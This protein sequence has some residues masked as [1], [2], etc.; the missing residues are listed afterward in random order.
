MV[1]W[2]L[3]ELISLRQDEFDAHVR[4]KTLRLAFV[5]MSN[6]GKS[7]RSRV[8]RNEEDFLWYQVDEAIQKALGFEKMGEISSWLGMPTNDTYLEREVEYLQLENRFTKEAAMQTGGKNFVFDTTGSVVHLEP[9]TIGVLKTNCL[10]VHFD[11][12]EN[13]LEVM[14]EKFKREP[15][16]VAWCG[17]FIIET[18]ES[19]QEAFERSY[20]ALLQKR[21]AM[22]RALAHINIPVAEIRDTS[23]K[24]TLEAIKLRL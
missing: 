19:E 2:N 8:L 9:E 22:Y 12:G 21:L 17:H 18:G 6:A 20:S 1:W 13:S 4:D 24:E 10:V 23:G 16:P 15:K 7:Y 14:L 5:G 11:V 3:M